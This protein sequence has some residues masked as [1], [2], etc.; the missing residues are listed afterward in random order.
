MFKVI[1]T[2]NGKAE[3]EG[4]YEDMMEAVERFEEMSEDVETDLWEKGIEDDQRV[5]ECGDG[6]D[7]TM[8]EDYWWTVDIPMTGESYRVEIVEE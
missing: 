7:G 3:I 8:A 6:E 2:R 5:D 1:V 4:V